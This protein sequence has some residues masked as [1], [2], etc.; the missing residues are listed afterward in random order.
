[1][2]SVDARTLAGIARRL[3]RSDLGEPTKVVVLCGAGIS[4]AAGIPDYRRW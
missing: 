1:M 4:T 2:L 3:L